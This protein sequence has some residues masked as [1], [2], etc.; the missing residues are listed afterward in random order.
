M[1]L[2]SFG[3][4]FLQ[5]IKR[6]DCMTSEPDEL[7]KDPDQLLIL[8]D[9]IQKPIGLINVYKGVLYAW[10]TMSYSVTSV[11]AN[12][13]K[14]Y[15]QD[16]NQLIIDSLL[17]SYEQLLA[18]D[19][20]IF[21]SYIIHPIHLLETNQTNAMEQSMFFGLSLMIC[22]VIDTKDIGKL[23]KIGHVLFSILS[24]NKQF[25]FFLYPILN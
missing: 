23:M 19:E 12:Y 8:L 11:T 7:A 6:Y 20:D 10:E 22:L 15:N 14:R 3:R 13:Y 9:S 2:K 1:K 18:G 4:M 21:V 16:A 25:H 24:P 17:K 5:I